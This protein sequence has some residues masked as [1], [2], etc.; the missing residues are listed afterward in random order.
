MLP[1][2]HRLPHG[3]KNGLGLT[4]EPAALVE[5]TGFELVTFTMRM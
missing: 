2:I 5:H 4:T 3:I 1:G